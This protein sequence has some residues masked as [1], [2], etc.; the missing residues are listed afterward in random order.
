[1]TYLFTKTCKLCGLKYGLDH[2]Q[3]NGHCPLCNRINSGENI[4]RIWTRTHPDWKPVVI[5]TRKPNRHPSYSG[6]GD[7]PTTKLGKSLIKDKPSF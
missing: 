2:K 1:M 7:T 5:P 6:E 4:R 3:D